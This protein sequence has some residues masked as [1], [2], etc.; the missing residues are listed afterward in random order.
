MDY[1]IWFG[2]IFCLVQSAI[3]SGL[4]L[5]YFSISRLRL[6][7]EVANGNTAAATILCLRKDS[8]F[9]LTTILWGNVG[10]NV[11][12][13]LLSNS[14]MAGLVAFLFSTVVIT[15]GGEIAPQAYFS[16]NALRMAS[17]LT[18]V[19]RVYQF[20]LY[21]IA[22]P[23]AL[24]LDLWLGKESVQY[25]R[26]R[27]LRQLLHKHI[28]A[29]DSDVDV[30]EGIGALNFLALDDVP[31]SEEGEVLSE[32]S[33][34]CADIVEHKPVFFA[35]DL[36]PELM[37]KQFAHKLSSIAHQ[38]IVVT[39]SDNYPVFV[40]DSDAYLRSVFCA[41]GK[42]ID[43]FLYC[44]KPVIL[45]DPKTRLGAVLTLMKAEEDLHSDAPLKQDLILLWADQKRIVT[46]AD[47]LGRLL[48]GIGL[49]DSLDLQQQ[50]AM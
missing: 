34:I 3:F 42:V 18:P 23:S 31:V 33:I 22:K 29:E 10:I 9:L 26:E 50:K 24:I 43:P 46:G 4:N 5:A 11:L 6:E 13:T 27:E 15:I 1:L 37:Q 39:N 20:V 21:I 36:A 8:N 14:V 45:E 38:W 19:L 48:K 40:L 49:Y 25:F 35:G 44:Y 7:I 47:I 28:D 30:I 41:D 16:R 32:Q 17:M 12:L 2:I